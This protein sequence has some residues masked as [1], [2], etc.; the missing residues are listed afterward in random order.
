[1]GHA[2]RMLERVV[3]HGQLAL[4]VCDSEGSGPDVLL[5][6]GL[7]CNL[8]FWKLMEPL[9]APRFRLVSVDLP[10]HGRSTVPSSHSFE[11]DLLALEQ[12]C[13]EYELRE[14]AIVGHSYGGMLA[15][16]LAARGTR[17]YRVA[18]N[19]D[20]LG[21]AHPRTPP[22]MWTPAEPEGWEDVGDLE[23]MEAEVLAEQQ[24]LASV[25]VAARDLPA[26]IIRRGFLTSGDGQWHRVPTAAY[27]LAVQGA[28]RD[29][30]LLQSYRRATCPTITVIA[31]QRAA[32]TPEL[33]KLTADHIANITA[34]LRTVPSARVID[35]E[36]GHYL[37][38]EAPHDLAT[39]LEDACG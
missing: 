26:E 24:V 9:L 22:A 13:S 33:Q 35:M 21:F 4:A 17:P 14:P 18:V 32:P 3:R 10:G 31:T 11:H 34:D 15:V 12:V 25:G 2:A 16:G 6:H 23:W 28:F 5:L 20:G 29:L 38:L 30:D 19:I 7:G 1:M 36:G 8:A 27:F 37:H 39:M